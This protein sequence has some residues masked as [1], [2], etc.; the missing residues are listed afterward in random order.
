M[1][2]PITRKLKIVD[3]IFGNLNKQM[4]E[5]KYTPNLGQLLKISIDLKKYLL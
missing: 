3:D 1:P 5:Q 2:I 4:M